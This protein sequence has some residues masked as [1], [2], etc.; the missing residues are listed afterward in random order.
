MFCEQFQGN[1]LDV[2]GA[3][4]IVE[5]AYDGDA[6]KLQLAREVATACADVTDGDRCEAAFK[7]FECSHKIAL[8]KGLGPDDI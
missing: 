8:D 3:V 2:E 5:K 7:I 6:S 4:A 1:K